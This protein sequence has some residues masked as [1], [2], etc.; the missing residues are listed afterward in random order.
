MSLI[1]SLMLRSEYKV[2]IHELTLDECLFLTEDDVAILEDLV[3][4]VYWD[5]LDL[6]YSEEEE[7]EDEEE[8]DYTDS[9]DYIPLDMPLFALHSHGSYFDPDDFLDY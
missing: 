9:D 4:D 7:D 3:V 1:D 8:E 5:G 2:P 6:G